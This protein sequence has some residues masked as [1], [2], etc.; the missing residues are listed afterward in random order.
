MS[1]SLPPEILD[2]IV[3]HLHDETATLRACCLVS[4]SW[5]PRSRIHLFDHVEFRSSGRT[6]ESWMKT[7]PDP[8]NSPAYYTRSLCLSHSNANSVAIADCRP[9]VH[10]FNNIADLQVAAVGYDQ[11]LISLT[12]LHGLSPSLRSIRLF[13][14]NAPLSEVLALIFSFRLLED[15]ALRSLHG[16]EKT[17]EWD[18]PPISPKFTG[19]L[20]L[21]GSNRYVTRKLLEL[22][23]GLHFSKIKVFCP[24][25]D[26]DL[27]SELVSKCSDTLEFLLLEF[28]RRTFS[29]TC[30]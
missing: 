21:R 15:L 7:F 18:A 22:P 17:D 25:G 28:Y 10:S 24:I 12:Q 9:W 29:T 3:D 14:S 2:L 11:D 26:G 8:S 4:G 20:D 27:A 23:G 1:L 5:I 16:T 30:S 6:L 13:Y 19:T